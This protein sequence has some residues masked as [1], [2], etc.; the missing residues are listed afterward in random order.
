MMK[1][2]TVLIPALA[3][4]AAASVALPAAAQSRSGPGHHG[5]SY[6]Q[7]APGW[8]AIAQRKF[9]LERQIDRGVSNRQISRRDASALKDELNRLVRLENS[10]MRGGLSL[11][12]RRD[13]D[14]RYDRL[15]VRIQRELS[16]RNSRPGHR[17]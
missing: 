5:P 8:N 15:S 11:Q 17:R 7:A 14:T 10:Y 6:N 12:E 1:K 9:T 16:D 2:A 3:V 13:L 4:V